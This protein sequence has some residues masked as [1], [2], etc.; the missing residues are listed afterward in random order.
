[1]G[2]ERYLMGLFKD[3]NQVVAAVNDEVAAHET[4][5]CRPV[6][7]GELGPFGY[8]RDGVGSRDGFFDAVVGLKLIVAEVVDREVEVVGVAGLSVR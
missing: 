8:Q 2:P 5:D 6:D 1:M 7:L 3:K 4:F